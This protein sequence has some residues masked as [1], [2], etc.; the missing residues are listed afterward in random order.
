MRLILIRHGQTPSNV[1]G[2]LDTAHPGPGLTEHGAL[3]A[4]EIPEALRGEA[5]D[6]LFASTL[7]RTQLTAGPLAEARRL[8]VDVRR[9]LHE[10]EAGDLEMRNDPH[11][12]RVYMET[13]F[14]WGSGDRSVAMPGGPNGHD[15]FER[16]DSDLEEIAASGASTAAVVSHGAAIRVWV[17]AHATNV[18]SVF[19]AENSL[20]NTGVVVVDGSFTDGW[21][22]TRWAGKPIGGA[23]LDDA[24]AADPT[25]ETLS[26]ARE[27][28]P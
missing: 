21:T 2:K 16:Y 25:G 10:I 7:V 17:A 13:V 14:A 26:E 4:A 1:L 18:P 22:L 11:S 3:Q 24:T 8:P 12:V 27:D 5:I 15:F 9:G 28:A 20:E 19:A 23:E 6:A